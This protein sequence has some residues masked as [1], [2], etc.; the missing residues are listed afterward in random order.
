MAFR[1]QEHCY[2]LPLGA[3]LSRL[4]KSV[5]GRQFGLF[6]DLSQSLKAG[7][8]ASLRP[9]QEISMI[10]V[11]KFEPLSRRVKRWFKEQLFQEIPE[12]IALCEFD[13][14]KPQCRMGEWETCVRRLRF[15]QAHRLRQA[16]EQ[17]ANRPGSTH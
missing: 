7:G 2:A 8:F 5:R 11:G 3:A 6:I 1:A 17:I 15:Q 16:A 12:D 13:C 4:R 14:R 9:K 10:N